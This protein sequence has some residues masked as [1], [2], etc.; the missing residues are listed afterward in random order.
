M[1]GKA[2]PRTSRRR[3]ER[4]ISS[5]SGDCDAKFLDDLVAAIRLKACLIGRGVEVDD[6]I[7]DELAE[8]HSQFSDEITAY[9]KALG[10][11]PDVH[12][13]PETAA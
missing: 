9:D 10:A 12:E 13:E 1:A 6:K 3:G 11:S 4:P 5:E 8:F 7:L 2:P